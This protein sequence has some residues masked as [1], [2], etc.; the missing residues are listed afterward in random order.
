M[1]CEYQTKD[2]LIAE[3]ERLKTINEELRMEKQ[4]KEGLLIDYKK[5]S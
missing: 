3:L 2:E 1:Q 5:I 4:K